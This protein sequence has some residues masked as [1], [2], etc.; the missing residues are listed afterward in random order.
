MCRKE[1]RGRGAVPDDHGEPTVRTARG[2]DVSKPSPA[3]LYNY[4][5]GG[6]D[7]FA[8]DREAAEAILAVMPEGRQ[9]AQENRAFLR[10]MVHYLAA[11]VGIRQFIDLGT[12]LPTQG[13]VHE[14]AQEAAAGVRV[15]YV[16]NDPIVLAHGEALLVTDENTTFIEADM[17]RPDLILAHPR[18]N[19]LIDFSQ[20]VAV[21]FVST[22]QFVTDDDEAAGLVRA[23]CDAVP[24]GSHVA[25]STI[26]GTGQDEDKVKVIIDAYRNSTAPAVLRTRSQIERLFGDLELIA[27]GLVPAPA[28]HPDGRNEGP[29][30]TSWVLAG[31]GRVG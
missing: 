3:R 1:H 21:L 31:V 25:I 6:K 26:T 20:P 8:A 22:L 9:V 29:D 12:G 23:F 4:Y 17:R 18:L 28:W 16:D 27:P 5:L 15:V 14:V 19:E 7:N 30:G 13:N 10:R 2:I 24:A 11:Q